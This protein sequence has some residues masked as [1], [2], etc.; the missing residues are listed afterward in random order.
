M[1]ITPAPVAPATTHTNFA[2]DTQADRLVRQVLKPVL[3]V[4]PPDPWMVWLSKMAKANDGVNPKLEFMSQSQYPQ[5]VTVN[6]AIAATAD[7]SLVLLSTAALTKDTIL[8]DMVTGEQIVIA[9]V[10]SATGATILTRGTYGGGAPRALA[11]GD[12][13]K[14]LS[15]AREEG[16]TAL[17]PI[18]IEPR[19]DFNYFQQF[20]QVKGIT[21]FAKNSLMYGAQQADQETVEAIAE[22][23]KR[24]V[25]QFLFGYRAEVQGTTHK[26]R[27][28]GGM[29]DFCESA[30][31]IADAGGAFTYSE[32]KEMMARPSRIGEGNNKEY[33][34]LG[35]Y[36]VT[37]IMSNWLLNGHQA[38]HIHIKEY[39]FDCLRFK[40]PGWTVVVA[41]SEAF[42]DDSV[43][44]DQLYVIRP[45]Y[46]ELHVY[47]GLAMTMNK[48]I[49]GPAKDGD[50]TIRDQMTSTETL[51]NRMPEAHLII[52]NIQS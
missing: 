49:T 20:E 17:N 51:A 34:A 40:G 41:R 38:D 4:Y 48:M 18:G 10:D 44:S 9:S 32:F 3:D 29:R 1:P 8:Q 46:T 15:V 28:A 26:R 42:E 43:Y 50:H 27:L 30:D 24:R 5:Y 52:Q 11:V 12:T 31:M 6:E 19:F 35:S 33:I 25:K 45:K 14:I 16:G 2:T 37:N 39:G 23:N 21:D 13:L 7:T 47:K 36:G 22:Y